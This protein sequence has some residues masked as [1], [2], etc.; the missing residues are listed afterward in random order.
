MAIENGIFD[1]VRIFGI[2][3]SYQ[4][5]ADAIAPDNCSSTDC[6]RP[7]FYVHLNSKN[8]IENASN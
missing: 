5:A 6:F 1:F 2:R 4:N 8:T 3:V 7:L